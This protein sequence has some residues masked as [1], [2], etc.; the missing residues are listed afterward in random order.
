MLCTLRQDYSRRRPARLSWSVVLPPSRESGPPPYLWGFSIRLALWRGRREKAGGTKECGFKPSFWMRKAFAACVYNS[1]A[2]SS[3]SWRPPKK[4]NPPCAEAACLSACLDEK[5]APESS[6]V[7]G[8]GNLGQKGSG[9]LCHI[10]W[11]LPKRSK[12]S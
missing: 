5:S 2:S 7:S 8:R 3:F 10:C 11:C 9:I 1:A 6:E 4:L 12:E